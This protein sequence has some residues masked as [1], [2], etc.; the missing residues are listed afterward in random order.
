VLA[1]VRPLGRRESSEETGCVEEG[2]REK[3]KLKKKLKNSRGRATEGNLVVRGKRG[4][5]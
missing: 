1:A 5:S 4:F 3:W 2:G